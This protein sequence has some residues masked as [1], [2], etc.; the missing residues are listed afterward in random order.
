MPNGF[1]LLELIVVMLLM[2]I[3]LGIAAP[4]L[5]GTFRSRQGPDQATLLLGLTKYA[6]AQAVVEGRV[7]RL[8]LDP[9]AGGYWLSALDSG[10]FAEL[11]RDLGR[12]RIPPEG[13]SVALKGPD[14]TPLSHVQF[15]PDGRTDPA[16]FEVT[17]RAGRT[18]QLA[19]DTAVDGFRIAN[20]EKL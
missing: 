12:R 19:S 9:A 4:D 5:R 3:I 17:D 6:R 2:G 8:N 15:Y 11:G 16:V 13:I 18:W 14:G 10:N 7:Y 1:T 20:H